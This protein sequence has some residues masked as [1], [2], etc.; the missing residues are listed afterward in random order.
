[1]SVMTAVAWIGVM[2]LAAIVI[3]WK[4][5]I[6]GSMLVPS[7]LIAGIIGFIFMNTT[8]LEGTKAAD[9]GLISGQLYTFLFI[10]LG[11]TLP[12]KKPGPERL[13]G[14][15]NPDAGN[16]AGKS[17]HAGDAYSS[18]GAASSGDAQSSGGLRKRIRRGMLSGILGM[19]SFWAM[20]YAFQA[21]IG[22]GI[23]TVIGG[24]WHMDRA[25][26][27]MI[28]FG[29]AQGPGQAVTYG[30]VIE[31][32]G[33]NDAVQV[34]MM[35]AA[36]GFIVAF[37]LG[38]PFAR[39]GI[40]RGIAEAHVELSDSLIRGFFEPEKQE[41]YGKVT[42]YGGNLDVMTLHI[43][44]VGI[45]WILGIQIGKLWGL[46]PGYFGQLFSQLLFFNGMLA[47]YAVR[48]VLTRMGFTKFMD[49][50]TQVRIT[51]ASTDLMVAATF[52]AIDLNIVGKWVVPILIIC[53]ATACVT[54]VLIRYFGARFGGSNDFERTLGEWGT[55]TGTN[56]TGLSLVRIADPDNETTT[57]AELGPANIVNVPASYIVA[58]AICAFC[59][60][61]MKTGV[62][63]ASL[64]GVIGGYLVFMRITG[65]WGKK[66][67]DV[68]TGW[69]RDAGTK[70]TKEQQGGETE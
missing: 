18:G 52:F 39:K 37:L 41:S 32:A 42:S 27:L 3:R 64:L 47:A 56:A 46:I 33:W 43:A 57:A 2:F 5:R 61:S 1:M 7:C 53:A 63:L 36:V 16:S 45:S 8:G 10:N 4:V 11:L 48:W 13:P 68:R 29:F 12:E 14:A 22:F 54:W 50:G 40:R 35:F 65:V 67:Y 9:Y 25:Y 58:P 19:G 60:G 17:A 6:L 66:T 49:R 62:L 38:V 28:P 15:G 30:S 59:A 34:A 20:A 31:K 55:V 24:I 23:L 21:L 44:L 70:D 26:G 51:N 69:K